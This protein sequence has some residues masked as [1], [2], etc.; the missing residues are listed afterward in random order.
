MALEVRA[1]TTDTTLKQAGATV[2]NKLK[3]ASLLIFLFCLA[4]SPLNGDGVSTFSDSSDLDLSGDVLYAIDFPGTGGIVN[5]VTFTDE[6]TTGV[7]VASNFLVGDWGTKPDYGSGTSND[8]LE[9]I[10][11][12][13]RAGLTGGSITID[14]TV[15]PTISYELQMMFSENFWSTPGSRTFDISIEGASVLTDFDILA[16]TGGWT[17]APTMGAVYS[18]DPILAGDGVISI[19]LSPG[20]GI[21]PDFNPIINALT[22]T[23]VPEPSSFGIL[24]C[25]GFCFLRRSN[26][27]RIR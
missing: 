18:S 21:T 1:D 24:A 5:G 8:N 19:V 23:S 15:D 7:S 13:I 6:T 25:V 2:I 27:Q 26:R 4:A 3:F 12:G 14:L 17:T 16:T 11:H 22:L 20:S 9:S 10:M